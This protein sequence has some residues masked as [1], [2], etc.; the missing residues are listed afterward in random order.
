MKS[1]FQE[2]KECYVCGK[3]YPLHRHHIYYGSANR[4]TSEKE[5]CT[6][7][8][9]P[10]HHNTGG[11]GIHKNRKLDLYIKWLCQKKWMELNDKTEQD[12]ID[13]FGRSYL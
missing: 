2:E 3:T 10:E 11:K 5:G 1:I 12:F 13:T 6:V 4:T 9:C 7:Y 8:L